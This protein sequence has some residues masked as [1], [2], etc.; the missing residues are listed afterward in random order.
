M[1]TNLTIPQN[2]P[3]ELHRTGYGAMYS[4]SSIHRFWNKGTKVVTMYSLSFWYL[5]KLI[6]I[7]CNIFSRYHA[8]KARAIN[9]YRD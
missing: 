5:W 3:T 1:E 2:T 6:T 9:N 4:S 7:P 8:I